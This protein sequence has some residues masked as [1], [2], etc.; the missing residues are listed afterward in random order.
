[1]I[2]ELARQSA[3]TPTYLRGLKGLPQQAAA[4]A[5]VAEEDVLVATGDSCAQHP[6]P[7]PPQTSSLTTSYAAA[8]NARDAA[9]GMSVSTEDTCAQ[10]TPVTPVP[11][12]PVATH[13]VT[14]QAP[15][16]HSRGRRRG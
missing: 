4:N 12:T 14:V 10:A 8:A 15:Q 7:K 6:S 13:A 2:P 3:V 11:V 5:K 16:R 1:M 9:E